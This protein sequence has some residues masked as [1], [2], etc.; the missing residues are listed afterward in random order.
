MRYEIEFYMNGNN[1]VFHRQ[2]VEAMPN[3]ASGQ[4]ISFPP[5]VS[6]WLQIYQVG[7]KVLP[8]GFVTTL[9]LGP[10]QVRPAEDGSAI[11]WPYDY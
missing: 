11:T 4:L 6:N 9:V 8:E 1:A 3:F 2:E 7:T 10:A 5:R